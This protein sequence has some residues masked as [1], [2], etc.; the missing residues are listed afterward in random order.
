M[1][2]LSLN[3]PCIKQNNHSDFNLFGCV[4][5]PGVKDAV[6]PEQSV[7]TSVVVQSISLALAFMCRNSVIS[8]K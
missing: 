2:V 6:L 5:H 3:S 4:F 1:W 7:P 8:Q